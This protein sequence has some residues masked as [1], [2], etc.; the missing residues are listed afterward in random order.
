MMDGGGLIPLSENK[1]SLSGCIHS[2]PS[3]KLEIFGNT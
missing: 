1:L 2:I 3:E